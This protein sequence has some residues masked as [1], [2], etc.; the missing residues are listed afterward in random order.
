MEF[1]MM[2]NGF[3]TETEF[4]SLIVSGD[5]QYGFRPYQL[6]V[7]SLAVCSGGVLRNILE[8]M[9]IPAEDIFIQVKE[10]SRNEAIANR[11]EKVHL[12]FIIKGPKITEAKM[13]K[14]MELT[15]KN[16]SMV[17]SVLNSIEV[18]DSFEIK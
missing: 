13:E 12:H 3:K 17:Q 7:S 14:A 1:K 5:D 2:D 18:V 9:R 6:L 16:C 10:V 15:R 11:L 4:G 8:K